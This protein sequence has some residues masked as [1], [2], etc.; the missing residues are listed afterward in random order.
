M[1]NHWKYFFCLIMTGLVVCCTKKGRDVQID[2]PVV[3]PTLSYGDSIFYIL[4]G[5]NDRIITPTG[6]PKGTYS[7]FPEGIEI[8]EFT[9]AI[10]V[11]KSESGLRYRISFVP[12]GK[13]DTVSTI[14][15]ISGINYIDKIY[16]LQENDTLAHAIYNGK[17]ENHVPGADGNSLFDEGGG[18]KAQGIEVNATNGT[19]DLGA[20]I[21]NGVLG[22]VPANGSQKEVELLYR[23][24]DGSNKALNHLKV[25]FYYFDT[26]QDMTSD[27]IQLMSDRK[28]MFIGMP[29]QAPFY[30]YTPPPS[31]GLMNISNSVLGRAKPRP[32]CIFIVGR[33]YR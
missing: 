1:L 23:L 21:R 8:N 28:G 20:I 16:S 14:I 12:E 24:N 18:C 6:N 30:Q 17:I 13:T 25:K 29:S 7:G 31:N 33:S 26:P 4:D 5:E 27:L 3:P 2:P 32:P 11:D 22:D 15:L 19:I 9:G 10:N